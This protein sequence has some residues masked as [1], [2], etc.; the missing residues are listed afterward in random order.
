M[1]N[2]Y[3][4]RGVWNGNFTD[5]ALNLLGI[6]HA[7]ESILDDILLGM[8]S[9]Q[10]MLT[11]GAGT[12]TT[13]ASAVVNA[14]AV[15]QSGY[16]YAIATFNF[17]VLIMFLFEATTTRCWDQMT[18]FDYNNLGKLII[19]TSIGGKAIGANSLDRP[20]VAHRAHVRVSTTSTGVTALSAANVIADLNRESNQG[21]DFGGTS[22]Q[23]NDWTAGTTEYNPVSQIKRK[24]V[25]TTWMKGTTDDYGPVS[26]MEPGEE[27]SGVHHRPA[28]WKRLNSD[29][30]PLA[31]APLSPLDLR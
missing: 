12:T 7:F 31:L 14:I 4:R 24:P 11:G 15:G 9:A 20:S 25:S 27:I 19:A 5:E 2:E 17:L 1:Q 10:I 21:S 30:Q 6:E 3:T 29:Y 18:R 16:I 8:S 28:G 23:L 22:Y 26:S 13:T